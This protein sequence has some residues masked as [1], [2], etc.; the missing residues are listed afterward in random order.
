MMSPTAADG[1]GASMLILDG[2]LE[3]HT[4]LRPTTLV[5]DSASNSDIVFGLYILLGYR[6]TPAAGGSGRDALLS[7]QLERQLR[8]AQQHRSPPH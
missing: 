6:F 5:T 2:L 3:Q 1:T 8:A 7:H 4:S